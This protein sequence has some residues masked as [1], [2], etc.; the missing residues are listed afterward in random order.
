M[1]DSTL[2]GGAQTSGRGSKLFGKLGNLRVG[3]KILSAVIVASIGMAVITFVSILNLSDLRD[4]QQSINDKALEPALAHSEVESAYLNARILSLVDEWIATSD[5]PEHEAFL[6]ATDAMDAA[7]DRIDSVAYNQALRDA[8]AQLRDA[9]GNYEQILNDPA[10]IGAARAG[11]RAAFN[12]IRATQ[13]TPQ[14]KLIQ[15]ALDDIDRVIDSAAVS[16]L[17]EAESAFSSSRTVLLVSAGIALLCSIALAL[18]ASRAVTRPLNDVSKVLDALAEGDLTKRV[19]VSSKDEVGAMA[20]SL[21]KATDS[22]K[23]TV[24]AIS[25]GV[26]S[27]ESSAQE[28]SMVANQVA[29]SAEE[30]SAQ[31][32]V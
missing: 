22:M 30:T 18:V 24:T 21:N 7:L 13:V 2:S 20:A 23:Q 32:G 28:L 8:A 27:L 29:A 25:T 5:G 26:V 4:G 1:T 10:Y 19:Q 12:E 16:Q 15:G 31:A 9:W 17:A 6:A 14:V 3:T 11:D